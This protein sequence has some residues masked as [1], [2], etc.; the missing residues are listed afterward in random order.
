MKTILKIVAV[1]V[2]VVSAFVAVKLAMESIGV[3][4]VTYIPVED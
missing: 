4:T 3:K 1:I 2:A